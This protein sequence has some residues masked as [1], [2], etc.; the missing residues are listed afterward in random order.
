MHVAADGKLEASCKIQDNCSG[1]FQIGK[2]LKLVELS[3]REEV[4]KK[5]HDLALFC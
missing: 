5:G 1:K 3:A 4:E 2:K